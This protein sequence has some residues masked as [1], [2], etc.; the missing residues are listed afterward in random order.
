MNDKAPAPEVAHR[1]LRWIPIRA[2]SA[3][4]RP[5]LKKHLLTLD[6]NDRYLRFGYP[7]SDEQIASYV[8][9][10]NFQRDEIFGVFSR[11][12]EITAFAHLAYLSQGDQLSHLAEFGVSVLPRARGRGY[13]QRLFDHAV[14]HARNGNVD[15]LIIQ[16]LSENTAMLRIVR[17]AGAT[18][19][20]D[21][22]ES[23]ARLVLPPET[24]GSHMEALMEEGAAELD[25]GIKLQAQTLAVV[26]NFLHGVQSGVRDI[27][28]GIGKAR[29]ARME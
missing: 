20:R 27:R 8:D 17:K 23:E 22:S 21:G 3:H 7:A 2:L 1:A 10:L 18:V 11:R 24:L 12:L 5:E 14:L 29:K 16:A 6:A 4:H 25:Y 26:G 9:H 15:T 19:E 28:S 13:G